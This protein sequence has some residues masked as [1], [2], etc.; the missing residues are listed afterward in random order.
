V[1]ILHDAVF[2]STSWNGLGIFQFDKIPSKVKFVL[3]ATTK[4][5]RHKFKEFGIV[6]VPVLEAMWLLHWLPGDKAPTDGMRIKKLTEFLRKDGF[7]KKRHNKSPQAAENG[8][9]LWK[10]IVE[11]EFKGRQTFVKKEKFPTVNIKHDSRPGLLRAAG[12]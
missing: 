5:Q 12:K 10:T 3:K 8:K 11:E 4:R 7:S 9:W 2:S 6:P 1:P